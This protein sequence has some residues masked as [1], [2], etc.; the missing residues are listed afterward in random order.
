MSSPKHKL[1]IKANKPKKPREKS[2]QNAICKLFNICFEFLRYSKYHLVM[3]THFPV[4]FFFPPPSLSLSLFA[5]GKAG[6]VDSLRDVGL[7]MVQLC[8]AQLEVPAGFQHGGFVSPRP[9]RAAGSLFLP[10]SGFLPICCF[11]GTQRIPPLVLTQE[12]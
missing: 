8:L 9:R 5:G 7:M 4:S 3:R 10:L 2:Q 6:S 1:S 12:S 11:Q